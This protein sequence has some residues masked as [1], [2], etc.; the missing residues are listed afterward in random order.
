M[1]TQSEWIAAHPPSSHPPSSGGGSG[2][3]TNLPPSVQTA[4]QLQ[5]GSPPVVS[6]GSGSGIG[7]GRTIS[8]IQTATKGGL[9][10]E[11]KTKEQLTPKELA[12]YK[13]WGARG[14]M[15]KEQTER[16]TAEQLAMKRLETERQQQ[17]SL[18]VQYA[19]LKKNE[20]MPQQLQ[21]QIRQQQMDQP[22][23][24]TAPYTISTSFKPMAIPK[25]IQAG[26]RQEQYEKAIGITKV[27]SPLGPT[28]KVPL[29]PTIPERVASGAKGFFKETVQSVG[30]GS[31]EV[32]KLGR[33]VV[34]SGVRDVK[35]ALGSKEPIYS[36]ELKASS[37][38]EDVN[39]GKIAKGA[40]T[41]ATGYLLAGTVPFPKVVNPI[42]GTVATVDFIRNPSPEKLGQ[43]GAMALVAGGLEIAGRPMELL[44]FN[45]LTAIPKSE[46]APYFPQLQ[47]KPVRLEGGKIVG[48][49]IGLREGQQR[50]SDI[51]TA[52]QI[53]ILKTEFGI[54]VEVGRPRGNIVIPTKQL[55][56]GRLE[57]I[58]EIP[59]LVRQKPTAIVTYHAG[60]IPPTIKIARGEP[61][62]SFKDLAYAE[63]WKA[64]QG[65]KDIYKIASTD[66]IADTQKYSRPLIVSGKIVA[67]TSEGNEFILRNIV[68]QKNILTG[69][70][71]KIKTGQLALSDFGIKSPISQTPKNIAGIKRLSKPWVLAGETKSKPVESG[72]EGGK[73]NL[74][75]V[76]KEP[77]KIFESLKPS[78]QG[79]LLKTKVVPEIKI[80]SKEETRQGST[81]K[82]KEKTM[83]VPIIDITAKAKI[84]S[85]QDI[86]PK[87]NQISLLIPTVKQNIDT[88]QKQSQQ[89]EQILKLD[90]I[91]IDIQKPRPQEPKRPEP[92]KPNPP[93][94]I[95]DEETTKKAYSKLFVSKKKSKFISQIKR[96]GKFIPI[97][98]FES[99]EKA[100]GFGIEK[101]RKTLGASTR[102]I[103]EQGIIMPKYIPEDFYLSKKSAG[104]IIQRRERRLS[105]SSEIFELKQSKRGRMKWF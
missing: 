103:S 55:A 24:T 94:P 51:F 21:E 56:L 98:S 91:Q 22:Y 59:R 100:L 1:V 6:Y 97:G 29:S 45:R 62:Y 101:T 32:Y 47:V 76:S 3:N 54:P 66:F 44:R 36:S 70:T 96:R 18:P 28:I 39:I 16:V 104:V 61:V 93:P 9:S 5:V 34:M 40:G 30:E 84:K 8:D 83:I 88:S 49:N 85:G 105:S 77:E 73:L 72:T 2:E 25:E 37:L 67:K 69:K 60:N 79:L 46:T 33:N 86:I 11:G 19:N 58:P 42:L 52:P 89:Q 92:E 53:K 23:T 7:G 75:S 4:I 71:T 26:I 57:K 38:L 95:L 99:A 68:S 90:T 50:F 78:G 31:V 35:Y 48:V 14:L 17:V 43:Y 64:K 10:I 82:K 81:S 15:P 65:Y 41:V 20:I 12:L 102:V 13:I 74:I 80:K 87:T 27:S 63:G